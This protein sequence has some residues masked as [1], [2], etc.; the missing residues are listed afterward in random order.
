MRP[1]LLEEHLLLAERLHLVLPVIQ[2]LDGDHVAWRKLLFLKEFSQPAR[3]DHW[4]EVLMP[5]IL[6]KNHVPSGFFAKEALKVP[7]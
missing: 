4:A 6:S 2:K 5:P 1:L 3:V 7:P